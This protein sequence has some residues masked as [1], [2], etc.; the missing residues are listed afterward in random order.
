MVDTVFAQYG[1]PLV[2]HQL[3]VYEIFEHNKADFHARFR[4]HAWR[5][6][7]TYGFRMLAAWDAMSEGRPEFVYLLEWPDVETMQQAW[8]RFLA[9]DEW[10]RIKRETAALHGDLVGSVQQKVLDATPYSPNLLG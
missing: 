2:I 9:D 6:M 4:D 8:E 1:R 7:Q 10:I 3:R 5:I